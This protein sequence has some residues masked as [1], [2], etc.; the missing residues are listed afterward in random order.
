MR[1]ICALAL[2]CLSGL[3]AAQNLARSDVWSS[4][5]DF[6]V[7]RSH[8]LTAHQMVR[9][10]ALIFAGTVLN[11]DHSTTSSGKEGAIT[12]IRFRVQNAIRGVRFGQVLEIREWG[13]LW[14]TG[15]RYQRGENVLLFLYPASKLGLTSPVA[16]AA[17]HFRV[18]KSWH[19]KVGND[20][21]LPRPVSR[22]RELTVR[23]FATAIRREA[24]E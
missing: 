13:G 8:P 22:Q 9:D 1:L 6:P 23:E 21:P 14:T 2:I 16:G 24:K 5:G 19:M 7:Q 18:D 4:A 12:R 15:E 20:T 17:G 3:S 11:V 10:S